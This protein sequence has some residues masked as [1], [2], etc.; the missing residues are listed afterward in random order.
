MLTASAA[1]S[2]ARDSVYGALAMPRSVMI[3]ATYFAGVTSN[4]GFSIST[5]SGT[6]CLPA[7]CVTS[8]AV[9]LLDGNLAAVGS[10]QVDRRNRRG[11][12]ERDAVFFRQDRDG[13]GADLVGH[14]A[15]GG[16]AVGADHDGADLALLHHGCRPCCRRSRWSGCRPSS[17][18]MR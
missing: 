12:I 2:L 18:P 14:V 7:M 11:H 1:D 15:V 8:L 16:D 10:C 5:P 6:I 17:V 9:A 3:A 13:I 4:A